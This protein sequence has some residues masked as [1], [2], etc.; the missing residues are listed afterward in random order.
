MV[1]TGKYLHGIAGLDFSEYPSIKQ[2]LSKFRM[3]PEVFRENGY[4]TAVIGKWHLAS[5]YAHGKVW[6]HSIIWERLGGEKSGDYFRDQKLRFDGGDFTPVDG[7]STDNYTRF[8]TE[9][10]EREH[11]QPWMLWLCYDA[12]HAPFTPA[13]RH[14][15]AY[16]G[17]VPIEIPEDIYPPRPT[18]PKYMRDY[19]MFEANADGIPVDEREGLTLPKL[20]QKYNSG[21]LSLDEGVKDLLDTLKGT[22]QLDNTIIVFTSD[23]GIAMGHHGMEIKV[24]PYDDNIRVPFIVRLPE[25]Q[26]RGSVVDSPVNAI[27]LIPTFFDYAGIEVPWEMHGDSLR[28]LMEGRPGEWNRPILQENFSWSFGSETDVGLTPPNPNQGV[29]WWIFVRHGD[30]KYITTLVPNEIEELYHILNDPRELTN[31]AFDPEHQETLNELRSMMKRE[32]KRTR[33]G[34]MDNLPGPRRL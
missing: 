12:V 34:L 27:D 6:D 5:D 8:A 25:D 33:A 17:A 23:Q 10:I 1:L 11:E 24:A 14:E 32:L 7:H 4:T 9:F 28:P 22:G 30:Y 19:S 29:D 16:E 13:D 15:G 2:D 26:S 21:V 20:V 18:K 31:L 3:W